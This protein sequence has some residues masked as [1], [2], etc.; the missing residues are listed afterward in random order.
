MPGL[1]RFG[2]FE[3]DLEAAELRTDGRKVRLPE[4]Q[5]QILHMLASRALAKRIQGCSPAETPR[6]CDIPKQFEGFVCH[7]SHHNISVANIAMM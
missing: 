1:M 6:L 3:L 7:S 5:F 2:P 4:Q